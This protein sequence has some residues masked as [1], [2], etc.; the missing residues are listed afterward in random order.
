LWLKDNE[1]KENKWD[2]FQERKRMGESTDAAVV[3]STASA[4]VKETAKRKM[5]FKEKREFELLE[6]EMPELEKEK[7]AITEKM[8]SGT[9]S[10]EELQKL[11]ER[12]L[13]IDQLMEEKELRWLELSEM[14]S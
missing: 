4:A 9:L 3:N 13:V 1:K 2:V 7:N 8:G 14:V 11:S 12:I 5:S 10:F 6:K